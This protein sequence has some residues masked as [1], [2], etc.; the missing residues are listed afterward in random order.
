MKLSSRSCCNLILFLRFFVDSNYNCKYVSNLFWRFFMIVIY[1]VNSYS[2]SFD[3]NDG[4][5][6]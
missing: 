6:N 5:G 3:Y 4:I 2:K 1:A